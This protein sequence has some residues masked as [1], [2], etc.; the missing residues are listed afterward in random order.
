MARITLNVCIIPAIND[1][2]WYVLKTQ[3][4][5]VLKHYWV[6]EDRGS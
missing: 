2:R 4:L 6:N 3:T 5:C 1:D